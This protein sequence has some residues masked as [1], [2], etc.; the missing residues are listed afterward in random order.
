LPVPVVTVPDV[1]HP[2]YGPVTQVPQPPQPNRGLMMANAFTNQPPPPPPD[3]EQTSGMAVNAFTDA[4]P[5]QDPGMAGA[6]GSS[7]PS[8]MPPGYGPMGPAGMMPP[9]YGYGY[10]PGMYAMAPQGGMGQGMYPQ[11]YYAPSA[12]TRPPAYLPPPAAAAAAAP[13][14]PPA[15]AQGAGYQVAQAQRHV[16]DMDNPYQFNANMT[17]A[18]LIFKL[19]ESLYPSQ[20]EWAAE[21]LSGQ[22]ARKNG[23]MVP[24]LVQGAREDPAPTVRAGCIRALVRLKANS[25]PV[26]EALRAL[27]NDRDAHVQ[28]EAEEALAT[29]AP[30]DKPAADPAVQRTS[31]PASPPKTE[32]PIDAK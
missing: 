7:R 16:T 15:C 11:G 20:R 2:P 4:P 18:Q 3:P 13:A 21:R 30:G 19:K 6:F 24:A 23:E 10:P 25:E 27:K 31:V 9:G 28:H 1:R 22:D 14:Q 12:P 17:A 5:P 8:M 26:V 29:L 32:A